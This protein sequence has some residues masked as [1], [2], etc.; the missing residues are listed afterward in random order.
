MGFQGFGVVKIECSHFLHACT[1]KGSRHASLHVA[2]GPP[3][4]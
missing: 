2:I 4:P 1:E 3:A